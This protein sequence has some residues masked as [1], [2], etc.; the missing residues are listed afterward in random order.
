MLAL[1]SM[2]NS[3]LYTLASQDG[4]SDFLE[5]LVMAHDFSGQIIIKI[6]TKTI[7]IHSTNIY[8]Q[9]HATKVLVLEFGDEHNLAW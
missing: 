9:L 4:F 7:F 6:I 5:F 2:C 3:K 1:S 8:C